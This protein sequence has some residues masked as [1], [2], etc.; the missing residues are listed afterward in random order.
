MALWKRSLTYVR[1]EFE[2]LSDSIGRVP[3]VFLQN[4]LRCPEKTRVTWSKL[5]TARVIPKAGYVKTGKR[6]NSS[7]G[8]ILDEYLRFVADHLAPETKSSIAKELDELFDQAFQAYNGS[9]HKPRIDRGSTPF[10]VDTW[11]RL[12][13]LLG[14]REIPGSGL[15][16]KQFFL[17]DQFGMLL[18]AS[19]EGTETNKIF[20]CWYTESSDILRDSIAL[21]DLLLSDLG[22]EDD[23]QV[24]IDFH[25]EAERRIREI[26]Q[27]SELKYEAFVRS[28]EGSEIREDRLLPHPSSLKAGSR[29]G[30]SIV[31]PTPASRAAKDEETKNLKQPKMGAQNNSDD[32]QPKRLR[33]DSPSRLKARSAYD[34]AM[35]R[36][37]HAN[38]MTAVELFD[39]IKRDGEAAEML[40]PT[41]EAFTRYLNDSGI[42]LRK[43]GPK[44]ASGSVIRQSDS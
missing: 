11:M 32:Q 40:P 15:R 29:D 35:E 14:K 6:G 13:I 2:K 44:S 25:N 38:K 18:A 17:P 41:P 4:D 19:T 8:V 22:R 43:S 23:A 20:K 9:P 24:V 42:R 12:M 28:L 10:A 26:T 3:T 31:V 27:L 37:D 5:E 36:F 7:D 34:Y 30:E 16:M 1:E 39:A 21:I 33:K